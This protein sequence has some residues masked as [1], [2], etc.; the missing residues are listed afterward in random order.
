MEQ[1]GKNRAIKME[2]LRGQIDV[3]LAQDERGESLINRYRLD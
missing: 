1:K 2:E 3:A